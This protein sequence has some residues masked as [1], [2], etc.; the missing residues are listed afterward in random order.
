MAV[1]GALPRFIRKVQRVAG[2]DLVLADKLR[3]LRDRAIG[4]LWP[5][6]LGRYREY[7]I[8]GSGSVTLRRGST[9][10]KVFEE[11]FIE[12]AY[13][14]YAQAVR[15][16]GPV[17]LIDLGANIGLSVISLARD[18]RP[19]AIVAVEPDGGNFGMLQE[20][21][22][23]T[24]LMEQCTA[25]QAFAGAEHASRNWWIPETGLGGCAWE[26]QP[27]QVSPC[28]RSLKSSIWP[29]A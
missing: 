18:L 6:P 11:I 24:G 19:F 12:G 28:C 7:R 14:P 2:S 27:G 17:I 22:R 29:A 21:L 16:Q 20:N 5:A 3:Y 4:S 15:R 25:I 1:T 23:R 13:T 9:D 26:R 10:E 8:R